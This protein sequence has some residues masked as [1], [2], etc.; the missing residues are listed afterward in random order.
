MSYC[1]I[2]YF[3]EQSLKNETIKQEGITGRTGLPDVQREGGNKGH[4]EREARESGLIQGWEEGETEKGDAHKT[5][6]FQIYNKNLVLNDTFCTYLIWFNKHLE[7]RSQPTLVSLHN[8]HKI[9]GDRVGMLHYFVKIEK[10]KSKKAR[11]MKI[12]CQVLC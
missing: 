1:L 4:S 8:G 12:H 11:L 6:L 3:V 7:L 2:M 10:K 9:S 5:P